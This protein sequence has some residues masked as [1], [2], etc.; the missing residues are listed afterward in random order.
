MDFENWVEDEIA[1]S[2][3]SADVKRPTPHSSLYK[4]ISLDNKTSWNYF[5]KMLVEN[6]LY[7]TTLRKLNDPFEG[8]PF[9]V[10][11]LSAKLIK[12]ITSN[13]LVLAHHKKAGKDIPDFN[14]LERYRNEAKNYLTELL[15]DY[16]VLSFCERG[17]SP[18]LWSHY[19]NSYKGACL[20]FLGRSFISNSSRPNFRGAKLGSVNYSNHR[21]HFPLSLALSMS[22]KHMRN[23]YSYLNRTEF[24]KF[25]FFS[26]GL[27]WQYEKKNYE[28]RISV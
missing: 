1:V 16:R 17:D 4:Y 23:R 11:D 19:A 13:S 24:E 8:V 18:L 7:G 12:T 3:S 21:P 5:E 27:D 20:H 14:D 25:C 2:R 28:F 6:K 10:D 15:S 26:K 9:I 22:Q